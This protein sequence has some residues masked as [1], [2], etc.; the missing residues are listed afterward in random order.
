MARVLLTTVC[1]PFGQD[2]EGP[3]VGVD[4]MKG[5][6]CVNQAAFRTSGTGWAYGLEYIANNIESPTVVLHWP[7]CRELIRELRNGRFDYVGVSYTFQLIPRLEKT[8]ALIRRYAPAARIILGGYG[9][10]VE[11]S[12][13]LGDIVCRGEGIEFVRDLLGEA[14]EEPIRHPTIVYRNR[15]FS[16]P[17]RAGRKLVLCSG[18][19]CAEGCDFCAPSHFFERR[20]RPF[21]KDGRELFRVMNALYE[22]TGL[23]EFLI[24]DENFLVYR[25]RAAE[26]AESCEEAGRSFEFFTFSSI[27]ALS[28]FSTEELIRIGISAVWIGLE[29]KRSG[30]RKLRGEGLNDL[31]RRLTD[32]GILVC[33]SMIIGFD[34]QTPEIIQEELDSFLNAGLTYLQCLMY[35][36]APGTPFFDRIEREKRWIGG[37]FGKGVPYERGDGFELAFHHPCMD[38][39]TLA[40]LQKECYD[41]DLNR[42]GFSIYRAIETWLR[43]FRTLKGRKRGFLAGRAGIYERKLREARSLLPVGIAN[44]PNPRV[45]TKLRQLYG[46]LLKEFGPPGFRERVLSRLVIPAA[47]KWTEFCMERN[48]VQQPKL[49]RRTYR[50]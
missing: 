43:G 19:G 10:A 48:I 25:K 31:V 30:Y 20:Y 23:D 5:Q 24:F 6:L 4:V 3:S 7:S 17:I 44:A 15:L 12:T 21:V 29:G 16:L 39:V 9:T 2:G 40:R 41:R 18:L 33:G 27:R 13:R 35:G 1:R 22:Q 36:P 34:Y 49:I 28:R 37:G 14:R 45:K 26:L 50:C 47:A 11:E 38:P 46:E 8:V 32:C 42:H